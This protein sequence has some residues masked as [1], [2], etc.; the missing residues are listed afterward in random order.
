MEWPP[1]SGQQ[2]QFPE[3]DRADFFDMETAK[4]KINQAQVDLLVELAQRLGD[5]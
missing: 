5:G 3:V 4:R 2:M 1:K